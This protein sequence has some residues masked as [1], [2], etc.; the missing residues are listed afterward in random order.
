[1]LERL[2]L[3]G[4]E[5]VIDAG[6]GSGRV[7]RLLLDRLPHG[8]VIAVD[9]APSMTAEARQALDDRATVI[10]SD[11]V[12]LLLDEPADAA[13]S[14][15]VFHWV[16]DHD[17]LFGRLF[18]SLKPGAPL[19]A[20]CG[21]QGNIE[22]FHRAARQV[23][24]SARYKAHLGGWEGPWNFASPQD[25]AERLRRAGFEDV[26]TW[27]EPSTVRPPEPATFVR[28]VCLGHHL[29]SLPEELCEPYVVDVMKAYGEPMDLH[30]VRLNIT[31]RKSADV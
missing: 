22:A 2:P 26:R 1:M 31:A 5:T 23:G 10:T 29:D 4:D 8:H 27:L 6:C 7:T 24:E 15:A 21:G 9:A 25:T 30:Y 18:D 13:F 20:Q 16:P 17:A 12:D 3:H 28:V 19:V 11:L 14:N